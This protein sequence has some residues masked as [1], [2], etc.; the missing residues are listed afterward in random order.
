[1]K[2][3]LHG[4]NDHRVALRI[5]DTQSLSSTL[6]EGHIQHHPSTISRGPR[7][8]KNTVTKKLRKLKSQ[9]AWSLVKA[10]YWIKRTGYSEKGWSEMNWF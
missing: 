3:R 4:D 5:S 10:Q 6:V 7:K 9:V 8:K 1:M 2:L